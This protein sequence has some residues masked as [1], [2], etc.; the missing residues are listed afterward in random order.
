MAYLV[1]WTRVGNRSERQARGALL[2]D[3]SPTASAKKE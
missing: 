1:D 2:T 3:E